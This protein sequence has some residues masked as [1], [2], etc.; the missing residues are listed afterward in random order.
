MSKIDK[1]IIGVVLFTFLCGLPFIT[2]HLGWQRGYEANEPYIHHAFESGK[3]ICGAEC[4]RRMDA[5]KKEAYD[6]GFADGMK[7][8]KHPKVTKVDGTHSVNSNGDCVPTPLPPCSDGHSP[9][10]ATDGTVW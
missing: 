7:T 3:T 5:A 1:A 6:R 2:W 4:L 8:A 9:C 10:L